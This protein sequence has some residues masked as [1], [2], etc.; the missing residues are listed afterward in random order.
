MTTTILAPFA[1]NDNYSSGPDVGTPTKV[2]PASPSNGF[3]S[4]TGIA[5]QHVNY[6][7][8]GAVSGSRRAVTLMVKPRLIYD[9]G[10][11]ISFGIVTTV[12]VPRTL[13]AIAGVAAAL[14]SDLGSYETT[15]TPASITGNASGA[16]R[17]SSSGRI[18]LVGSGGNANCYSDDEGATWTAGGALGGA[19]THVIW[20][21]THAR[22]QALYAGHARY[23][24][25]ATAWTDVALT[26]A[27]SLGSGGHLA[28]LSNGNVVT[29][30][31]VGSYKM[32]TDGGTSWATSSAPPSSG[33]AAHRGILAG[34]GGSTIYHAVLLPSGNYQISASADGNTWSVV[35]TMVPPFG[36]AWD[37]ALN[38]PG[39]AVCPDT[40]WVFF[41]GTNESI[42]NGVCVLYGSPDAINWT[43]PLVLSRYVTPSSLGASRGRV[44]VID[45]AGNLYASD[46]V[47]L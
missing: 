38:G 7:L 29:D 26:G 34:N 1:T 5:P 37:D 9:A 12:T 44:F 28:V 24:T 21:A 25:D 41:L 27:G 23:S 36:M 39:L 11:E 30:V 31:G 42:G 32:S 4:G 17:N 45:S 14:V 47:A 20:N 35:S 3:V 22:F 6:L 10:S 8:N 16:A 33:T 43:D 19:A 46:G 40:G 2:D 15:G 18:V 13:I